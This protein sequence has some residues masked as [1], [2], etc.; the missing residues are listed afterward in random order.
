ME[1]LFG[2]RSGPAT[3]LT[4]NEEE[5]VVLLTNCAAL[6]YPRSRKDV[7]P[8][9]QTILVQTGHNGPISHGWWDSFKRKQPDLSLRKEESPS[10]P[11]FVSN[12]P[13]VIKKY[14]HL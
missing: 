1:V 2:S 9:V 14:F 8:M 12:S 10:C 13:E 4:E 3:L 11:R 6:G 7:L 5:L